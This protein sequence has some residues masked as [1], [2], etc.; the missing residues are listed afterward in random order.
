MHR[1]HTEASE[2]STCNLQT[3]RFLTN[4]N[5]IFCLTTWKIWWISSFKWACELWLLSLLWQCSFMV[6]LTPGFCCRKV[7]SEGI[8]KCNKAQHMWCSTTW[9]FLSSLSSPDFI[10]PLYHHQPPQPIGKFLPS[11]QFS[12]VNERCTPGVLRKTVHGF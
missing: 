7:E 3:G 6:R 11:L 1:A 8:T 2:H 4:K 12:F 10:S 5:H 9:C